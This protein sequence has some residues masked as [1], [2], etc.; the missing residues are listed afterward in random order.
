MYADLIVGFSAGSGN[1]EDPLV[2]VT[3]ELSQNYPNPFNP[4][5]TISFTTSEQTRA[6]LEVYNLIGQNIRTL[7]DRDVDLGTTSVTWD[8][9]D[10]HGHKAA[11][12]VYFYKL[13]AGNAEQVKKMILLR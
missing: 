4:T 9:N 12:G 6:T 8:G 11:S 10:E 2:P 1:N 5:T 3:V 7:L 13:T